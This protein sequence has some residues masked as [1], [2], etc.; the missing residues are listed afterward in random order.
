MTDN[1]INI[2]SQYLK[3]ETNYAVII[4]GDYG[5]GKT[6]FFKNDLSNEI[7]NIS[8]TKDEKKK[9]TPI[10]ISLFGLKSIE[11]IQTEIF[12]ELYPIL[13]NKKTKLAASIGKTIVRGIIGNLDDYI[14]DLGSAKGNFINYD[15]LVLC[16]DDLDRKSDDLNIKD[17]LGFIN[18]IVENQGAKVLIIANETQL[19]KD[20]NYT[21]ELKEKVIRSGSFLC[22]DSYCSGFRVAAR[23]KTNME[24]S[25][26]HTGFRCVK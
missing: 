11:E 17:V 7:R 2:F 20:K 3:I 24:T 26:E 10:H 4:N 21:T 6:H 14:A 18:S 8:T 23:M 12:V 25:L 1:L 19:L 16:F 5:T 15:Q 13:K 22:N 9:F